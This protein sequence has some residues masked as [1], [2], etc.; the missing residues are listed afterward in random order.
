MLEGPPVRYLSM[1]GVQFQDCG[2]VPRGVLCR[3]GV[4][5]ANSVGQK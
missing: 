1:E 4:F 3:F 5:A 2:D